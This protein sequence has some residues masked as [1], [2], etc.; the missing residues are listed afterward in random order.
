[1]P[2]ADILCEE[3]HYGELFVLDGVQ[4]LICLQEYFNNEFRLQ[5]LKLIPSL[6][7]CRYL[8]L[9]YSQS[10]VFHNRSEL[11][12]TVIGY[13]TDAI[14]K[15]EFFKRVHADTYRFPIQ[16]ARNYAFRDQLFFIRELQR[17][18]VFQ[19]APKQNYDHGF[20][21]ETPKAIHREVTDFDELFLLLCFAT[22]TFHQRIILPPARFPAR[23]NDLLDE[24]A[25]YLHKNPE[26]FDP[27]G[28]AVTDAL[29]IASESLGATMVFS[30]QSNRGFR[31]YSTGQMPLDSDTIIDCFIQGLKGRGC[32]LN[33]SE[34][35][36]IGYRANRS[37][38]NFL[39]ELI[40]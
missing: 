15:F 32:N 29:K 2:V 5:G 35:Q 9:P 4:R 22:L 6:E 20:S 24:A 14:L 8:D 39:K 19:L 13:D 28:K 34:S 16:L 10:S 23:F 30:S 18:N 40:A 11:G 27:L 33:N 3:N 7:G 17:S 12:L 37:P 1:M 21:I 38:Q 26:D 31:N 25:I 36:R